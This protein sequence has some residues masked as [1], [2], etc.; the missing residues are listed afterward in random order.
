MSGLI[1]V[2]TCFWLSH[3]TLHPMGASGLG[4]GGTGIGDGLGLTIFQI[5]FTGSLTTCHPSGT[6]IGGG[7]LGSGGVD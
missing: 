2:H 7:K 1:N 6:I 4:G 3:T 5:P